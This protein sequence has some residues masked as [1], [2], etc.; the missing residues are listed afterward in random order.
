MN[1]VDCSHEKD[2]IRCASTRKCV[3]VYNTHLSM[4]S[5]V[6]SSMSHPQVFIVT[7]VFHY[8]YQEYFVY[9]VT[10]NVRALCPYIKPNNFL[11]EFIIT[12]E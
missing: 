3:T 8:E 7:Q 2:S 12:Y 4:Y 5:C 9:V 6:Y 1:H 11:N 10:N